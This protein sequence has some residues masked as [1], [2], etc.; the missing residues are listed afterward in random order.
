MYG[1]WRGEIKNTEVK[2]KRMRERR[3]AKEVKW[4]W[5]TAGRYIT[6]NEVAG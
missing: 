4:M 1:V 2:M 6:I 3:G 5:A